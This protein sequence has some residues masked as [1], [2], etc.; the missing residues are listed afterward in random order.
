MAWRPRPSWV[1]DDEPERTEV[2]TDTDAGNDTADLTGRNPDWHPVWEPTLRA[3]MLLGNP[4]SGWTRRWTKPW[5]NTMTGGP[6]GR[7]L[8]CPRR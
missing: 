4:A 5:M 3:W 2:T 7:L 1:H 8:R 6:L